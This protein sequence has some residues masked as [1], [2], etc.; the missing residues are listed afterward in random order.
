M[1][2]ARPALS[3]IR[4]RFTRRVSPSECS[5]RYPSTN[6]VTAWPVAPA[7]VAAATASSISGVT[8]RLSVGGR[9][10]SSALPPRRQCASAI[11]RQLV[12]VVDAGGDGRAAGSVVE[13]GEGVGTEADHRDA[14]RFEQLHRGGHV[15]K[16]LDPGRGDHGRDPG[17]GGEIRGHVRR[18]GKAPVHAAE[19]SRAHEADPDR[20]GRGERASDRRRADGA[21]HG[22]DREIAR[23]ELPGVRREP[24]ELGRCE[25][26]PDLPVEHADGRRDGTRRPHGSLARQRPLRR[27]RAPGSRARR[28][29]SRARRRRAPPRAQPAPRR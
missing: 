29:S 16:R 14:E 8:S 11:A 13:E 1:A 28:E 12:H 17:G 3:T 5:W 7:A 25:P 20:G 6:G 24:L 27:R 22:A 2:P 26:D 23:A 9:P 18:C 4:S 21:L 15:E 10:T 19:A